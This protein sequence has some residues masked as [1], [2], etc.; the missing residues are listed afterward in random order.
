MEMEKK[1]KYVEFVIQNMYSDRTIFRKNK[2]FSFTNNR[3]HDQRK[4]IRNFKKI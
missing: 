1:E 4:R 2:S 3:L